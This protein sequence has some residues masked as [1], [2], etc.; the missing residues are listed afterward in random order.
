MKRQIVDVMRVRSELRAKRK[1]D[2]KY[3]K[4]RR[5]QRLKQPMTGDEESLLLYGPMWGLAMIA[6]IERATALSNAFAEK[7]ECVVAQ[8]RQP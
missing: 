2:R 6:R 5:R 8:K 1:Q 4:K 7:V 3:T